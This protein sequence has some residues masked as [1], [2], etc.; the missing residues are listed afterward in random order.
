[1]SDQFDELE[2]EIAG[3]RDMEIPLLETCATEAGRRR[4]DDSLFRRVKWFSQR[5]TG[6]LFGA[7]YEAQ[8]LGRDTAGKGDLCTYVDGIVLQYPCDE[9]EILAGL[10]QVTE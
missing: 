3:L 7:Q 6:E 2:F 5:E 1:M 4:C 10:V 9:V 8:G